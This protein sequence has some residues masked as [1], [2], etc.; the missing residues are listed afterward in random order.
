MAYAVTNLAAFLV[1]SVVENSEGTSIDA[2]RGLSQRSPLL[3]AG[4][5]LSFLSLAGVPPLAGFF[6]KFL[7]LLSA[8]KAGLLWIVFLGAVNVA[9]SLYYYLGVIR[10]MYFEK[11]VSETSLHLS[12]S[13]RA[14]LYGLVAGIV[15]IG[16]WQAPFF[17]IAGVLHT[18]TL[19]IPH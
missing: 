5:F 18:D 11:P 1:V 14:L 8:A 7:I 10:T 2:F 3:A 13:C 9:I 16:I 17:R 19:L 15:L 4:M 6:A 12:Y